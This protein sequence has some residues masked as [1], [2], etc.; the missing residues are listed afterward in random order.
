M[1]TAGKPRQSSTEVAGVPPLPPDAAPF[2]EDPN[3]LK[4]QVVNVTVGKR[5]P[6]GGRGPVDVNFSADTTQG[7][8][9]QPFPP[10]PGF[11]PWTSTNEDVKAWLQSGA[12]VLKHPAMSQWAG[13]QFIVL[14]RERIEQSGSALLEAITV[15]AK[16]GLVMP[17][18]MAE[19]YIG[20]FQKIQRCEVGS[21]DKAFEHSPIPPKRLAALRRRN[22]NLPRVS[23]L[24]VQKI[25]EDPN[26]PIG[27]QLFEEVGKIVGVSATVAEE[28]YYEGIKKHKMQDLRSLK[29]FGLTPEDWGFP[30]K[31][32]N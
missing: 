19:K 10:P 28:L 8:E 16:Q 14:N 21:L 12:L 15:I 4:A 24:L 27:K 9:S 30:A 23:A 3:T 2:K 29:S 32:K 22:I 11:N 6:N 25:K 18:W 1:T 17:D 7:R 13:A 26:R 31:T 5:R 20:C